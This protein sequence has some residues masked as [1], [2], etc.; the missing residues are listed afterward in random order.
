MPSEDW[1][2]HQKYSILKMEENSKKKDLPYLK[3]NI[4][5]TIFHNIFNSKKKPNHK[6]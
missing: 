4:D 1:R 2:N 5:K 6:K 3:L